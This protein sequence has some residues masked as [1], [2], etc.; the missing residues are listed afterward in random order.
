M[1]SIH[2]SLLLFL[3]TTTFSLSGVYAQTPDALR[4]KMNCAVRNSYFMRK[5]LTIKKKWRFASSHHQFPI[6]LVRQEPQIKKW[7]LLFPPIRPHMPVRITRL[8][9][10][11]NLLSETATLPIKCQPERTMKGITS[12]LWMFIREQNKPVSIWQR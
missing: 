7:N 5:Q 8:F 2:H 4:K 3:I 6:R 11:R 12:P 9:A 1:Q 10:C